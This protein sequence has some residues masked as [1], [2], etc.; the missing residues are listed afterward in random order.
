MSFL[1]AIGMGVGFGVAAAVA[2]VSVGVVG[3]LLRAK[4]AEKASQQALNKMEALIV[5]A[6]AA[7]AEISTVAATAK[8]DRGVN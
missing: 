4:M 1:I 3:E 7:Q 8:A 5:A 2:F 6:K